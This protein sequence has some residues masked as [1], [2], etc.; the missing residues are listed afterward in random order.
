M[1]QKN[2]KRAVGRIKSQL[3]IDLSKKT[4]KRFLKNLNTNGSAFVNG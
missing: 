4:L 1:S 2:L 3:D